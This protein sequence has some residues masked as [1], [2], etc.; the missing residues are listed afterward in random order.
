MLRQL[1]NYNNIPIDTLVPEIDQRDWLAETIF[2]PQTEY[3]PKNFNMKSKLMPIR[4]QGY[5]GSCVAFA[6][7]CMKEYQ[8]SQD[9]KL[10]INFS[11][12][13]LYNHRTNDSSGMYVRE[14]MK[15]LKNVGSVSEIDFRYGQDKKRGSWP[16]QLES[17]AKN[18]KI[19]SYALVSTIEGLKK[20]LYTNG[21]CLITVPVYNRTQRMWIPSQNGEKITGWHCMAVTGYDENGFIIRNSWGVFWG[22]E[23]YCHMSYSDWGLHSQCFTSVDDKSYLI[24]VT[25]QVTIKKIHKCIFI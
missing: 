12:Q 14:V 21:P 15:I 3:L 13:W 10:N 11:P 7:S 6:A 17:A 4:N 8:E 9:I 16:T 25:N 19:K 2:P 18:Y 24:H 1:V 20:A 5:Q 23:G 22:N